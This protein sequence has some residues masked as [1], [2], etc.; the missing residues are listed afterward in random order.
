MCKLQFRSA[1]GALGIGRTSTAEDQGMRRHPAARRTTSICGLRLV[2]TPNSAHAA[3]V[4]LDGDGPAIAAWRHI[5]TPAARTN[6]DPNASSRHYDPDSRL[7]STAG[8]TAIVQIILLANRGRA[9]DVPA[10]VPA[11]PATHC[12]GRGG[13]QTCRAARVGPAD[14]R[15]RAACAKTE[16]QQD[17][18]SEPR[19]M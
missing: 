8:R 17:C 15:L 4:A 1:N 7:G 16:R 14:K 11:G 13:G 2:A 5:D 6:T 3:V 9:L 18:I 10:A 12:N 19:C